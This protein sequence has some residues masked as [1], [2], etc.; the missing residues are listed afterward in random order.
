M[1]KSQNF[2]LQTFFYMINAVLSA[3]LGIVVNKI[4]ALYVNPNDYGAYSILFGIFS[5]FSTTIMAIFANSV[6]RYYKEYEYQGKLNELFSATVK[7]LS[8]VFFVFIILAFFLVAIIYNNID[9]LYFNLIFLLIILFIPDCLKQMG[10]IFARCQGKVV[11]QLATNTM[12]YVVKVLA[13]FVCFFWFK[14]GV[15]SILWA[16]LAATFSSVFLLLNTWKIHSDFLKTKTRET[17]VKILR[18]G[19]PLMAIPI[20]NYFLSTSD[21]V[22]IKMFCG[23]YDV[24]LYAMGYKLSSSIFSLSTTFLITS[25]HHLIMNKFDN[26]GKSEAESFVK[27]LSLLYWIICI[28]LLICVI[29]FNND[30]LKIMASE[31]YLES[32][33]VFVL[34]SIGIV[35]SGYINYTNKAWELSKKS[36]I[37]A[38]FSGAGSII[39][40]ILNFILIPIYGYTVAAI[41]TIISYLVVIVSSYLFGKKIL[42]PNPPVSSVI[43]LIVCGVIAFVISKIYV[44]FAFEGPVSAI[45]GCLIVVIAFLLTALLLLRKDILSLIKQFSKQRG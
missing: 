11:L 17:C 15:I 1:K 19:L 5:L 13:F 31:Q 41:T 25:S 16:T 2:I 33:L 26:Y 34:S 35:F 22:I 8:V 23:D 6:L 21:Q 10:T 44:L 24:G 3:V 32:S 14:K 18:F 20:I 9:E 39:N 29:V 38:L 30:L 37:I 7:M 27:N 12:E 36:W 42:N 28:P 4:F 40:I 43:K 45:L